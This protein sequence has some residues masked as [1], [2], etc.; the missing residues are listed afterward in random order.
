MHVQGIDNDF[1]AVMYLEGGPE[2][3]GLD[4]DLDSEELQVEAMQKLIDSGLVWRLQGSYG[5]A[6]AALIEAGVCHR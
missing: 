4:P 1:D 5:R 3:I 6:A 2:A